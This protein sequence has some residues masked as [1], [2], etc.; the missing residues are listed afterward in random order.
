M[1][2]PFDIPGQ[3]DPL[4]PLNPVT[5]AHH[6][7]LF[8]DV[9]NTKQA[10]EEFQ[11]ILDTDYAFER[12]GAMAIAVGDRQF[13]KTALLNRCAYWMQREIK[14]RATA[15]RKKTTAHIIDLRFLA[16]DVPAALTAPERVNTVCHHLMKKLH[17]SRHLAQPW[18]DEGQREANLVLPYLADKLTRDAVLIVMLP[19]T[20]DVIDELVVYAN[21]IPKRVVMLAETSFVGRLEEYSARLKRAATVPVFLRLGVLRPEDGEKFFNQRRDRHASDRSIAEAAPE[22]LRWL[23]T[24]KP[25]S[26]GE[27]QQVLYGLYDDVLRR[28][29]PAQQLTRDL[30]ADFYISRTRF[31]GDQ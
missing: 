27:L 7:D 25:T 28:R 11:S 29:S 1:T 4:K 8:I 26:V 30:I 19:P 16:G 5:D 15:A 17:D 2:N 18:Q 12:G 23:V 10:F 22:V 13:G 21:L 20:A 6:D 3:R 9:D 31:G 14:A 24:V